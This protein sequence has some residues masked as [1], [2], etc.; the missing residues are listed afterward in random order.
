VQKIS[1]ELL[2]QSLVEQQQIRV[3][4]LEGSKQLIGPVKARQLP[5]DALEARVHLPAEFAVV[6]QPPDP[7]AWALRREVLMSTCRHAPSTAIHWKCDR[8]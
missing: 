7:R 1:A 3:R 2:G 4:A 6:I 8:F 5:A